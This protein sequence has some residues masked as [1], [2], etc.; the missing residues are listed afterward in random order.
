MDFGIT[1]NITAYISKVQKLRS[2]GR[3]MSWEMDEIKE[4]GF[5]PTSP[6]VKVGGKVTS[7]LFNFP[8]DRAVQ[9]IENLVDASNSEL[10]IYKRLALLG[11]WSAWELGIEKDKKKK[12]E[13]PKKKSDRLKIR[14]KLNLRTKIE[15]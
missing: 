12:E 10:E 14:K 13:K 9:K 3:T 4:K 15:R 2:A 5:S 7:A 6:A 11:G 8:A 1:K